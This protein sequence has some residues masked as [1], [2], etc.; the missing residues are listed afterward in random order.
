MLLITVPDQTFHS[1]AEE[2]MAEEAKL[3]PAYFSQMFHQSTGVA[4]A[5]SIAIAPSPVL[6][7]SF[8]V[9]GCVAGQIGFDGIIFQVCDGR[10]DISVGPSLRSGHA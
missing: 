4:F 8:L 3:S 1:V 2:M 7:R 5:G 9:K 6:S 10:N